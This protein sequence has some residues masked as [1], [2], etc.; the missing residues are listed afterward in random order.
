MV[1]EALIC[2]WWSRSV[3]SSRETWGQ[4][5]AAVMRGD[6]GENFTIKVIF[7]GGLW[8]LKSALNTQKPQKQSIL[9]F[10]GIVLYVDWILLQ[11]MYKTNFTSWS[12]KCTNINGKRISIGAPYRVC[13]QGTAYAILTDRQTHRPSDR[14]YWLQ[15][16]CFELY[17]VLRNHI[18]TLLLIR[19]TGR[20]RSLWI[21]DISLQAGYIYLVWRRDKS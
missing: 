13:L 3:F 7:Q 20:L 16:S 15:V 18:N 4:T 12:V 2:I 19:F 11:S 17:G 6:D 21:Y 8:C 14:L 9:F 1:C 10:S 5:H